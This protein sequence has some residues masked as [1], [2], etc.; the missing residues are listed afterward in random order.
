MN[1]IVGLAVFALGIVLL[2]FGFNESRSFSSDV[3]RFFTGN[4][5]DRSMWMIVG[6]IVT[7]VAGLFLAVTGARKK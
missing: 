1:N 4:P 2:I 5:T 7:A 3:S 6:G